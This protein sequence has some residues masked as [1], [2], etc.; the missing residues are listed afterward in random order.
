MVCGGMWCCVVVCGGCVGVWRVVVVCCSL[1]WFV[2]VCGAVVVCGVC[3]CI[4]WYVVVCGCIWWLHLVVCR[5]FWWF[6]VV[7]GGLRCFEVVRGGLWWCVVVFSGMWWFVVVFA[8][9]CPYDVLC[10]QVEADYKV[11]QRCGDDVANLRFFFEYWEWGKYI[12]PE[13]YTQRQSDRA[14]QNP[15]LQFPQHVTGKNPV[16]MLLRPTTLSKTLKISNMDHTY[17][18]YLCSHCSLCILWS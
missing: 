18:R 5:E 6:M 1:W 11:H 7:H 16:Y 12:K 13:R 9:M 14:P 3:D 4:W 2:V 15:K 8:F 10:V 17:V